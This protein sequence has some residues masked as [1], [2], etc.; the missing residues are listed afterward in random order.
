M[1]TVQ[2]HHDQDA[3]DDRQVQVQDEYIPQAAQ[4]EPPLPQPITVEKLNVNEL[5]GVVESARPVLHEQ[6]ECRDEQ[7][8]ASGLSV[9]DG[10]HFD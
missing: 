1:G 10:H 8:P 7:P 9:E 2:N 6:L 3:S 5:I 4:A